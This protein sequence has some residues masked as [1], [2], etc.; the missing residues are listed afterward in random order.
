MAE[1]TEDPALKAGVRKLVELAAAAQEEADHETLG[2][3]HWL[4]ALLDRHGPMV[5]DLVPGLDPNLLLA[6]VRQ[7][8]EQGDTGAPLEQA[9]VLSEA[10]SRAQAR[11]QGQASERDLAVVILSAAGHA[12][13]EPV[14]TSTRPGAGPAKA[15]VETPTYR[16]RAKQATPA[17]DFFG[18]DLTRQAAEGKLAAV[19]GRQREL[20]LMV[21][22]LCRVT[23][24]NPALVGPAGVGKT[25]LVEGLARQIVA[26]AVPALLRNVRLIALQPSAV[27]AG[28]SASGELEKR[29]QQIVNEA[30]QDGVILFIDEF[31]TLVGAGGIPGTTD[32]ANQIKP[33]LA[34]GDVSCIAATTGEEYRRFI[35]ADPA[36]ERRFQP[37]RIDEPTAEQTLLMLSSVRDQLSQLRNVRVG[38]EVLAYLVRFAGEYLRNR[39]FPDKAVDLLEQCVAHAAAQG[40]PELERTEAEQVAQRTVGMPASLTDRLGQLGQ[41]LAQRNL[42]SAGEIESLVGRLQVTLRNLDLRPVRPNA[43][44]LLT[45]AAAGHGGQLAETIAEVLL[46]SPGRVVA[47][48]FARF[49]HPSDVALLLG[50]PPGYIGYSDALPLHRVAELNWCVLLCTNLHAC[51]PQVRDVLTQALDNGYLTE[52][53]GR[54]IYVSDVIVVLTA[55]AEVQTKGFGFSAATAPPAERVR[56]AVTEVLGP[57]LVAQCNL[58]AAPAAPATPDRRRWFADHLAADLSARFRQRGLH[59]RWDDSLLDWL[60]SA[61]VAGE[62]P[63]DWE[64]LVDDRLGVVLVAH[65]PSGGAPRA[66]L[67]R[68][69]G[70]AIR[71]EVLDR[72]ERNA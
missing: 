16:A 48:D 5:A 45:G 7:R 47:V 11:G 41:A 71:V 17:L 67:V 35:E 10:Q 32:L 50:A 24:R 29:M 3:H 69:A 51:H 55:E 13:K 38:D 23:K 43:V 26:G 1:N 62:G 19:V 44:V 28:L 60:V 40:K 39:H 65:L 42:L 46:G 21:E 70:D 54:R 64:R 57:S 61:S 4:V 52:S 15:P 36:L 49:A 2:L 6:Q 63:A 59:L 18:R 12:V 20:E 68:Y 30:S 9:A 8:L 53:R 31:H 33:A 34:R 37:V 27:V 56:E 25:A 58:I 72:D 14:W 66:V 22:T